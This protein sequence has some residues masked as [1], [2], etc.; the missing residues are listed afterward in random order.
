M[1][2]S[3]LDIILNFLKTGTGGKEAAASLK[4]V[5]K[6]QESAEGSSKSFS[7]SQLGLTA[8]LTGVTLA[9]VKQL[10]EL[11]DLGFSYRNTQI[12]LAAYTG[13]AEEAEELTRAVTE[14]AGGAITKMTAM[15]NATRLLSLGLADNADTAAELT[16]IA[17]TLG[18]TMGKDAT[19]AFE[20]FTLLL[21]NQSI[22][23]L[24]T[25][26]I[27][28]GLVRQRMEELA[29][30][31]PEVD[32]QT[33]FLNAT[34]EIARGRMDELDAAGFEATSSLDVLRAMFGD[35]KVEAATLVVNAIEPLID[36][37]LLLKGTV[38]PVTDALIEQLLRMRD[39]GASASE[40]SA[41][42]ARLADQTGRTEEEIRTLADSLRPLTDI[43]LNLRIAT[44]SLTS[45][46]G[47]LQDKIAQLTIK[48]LAGDMVDLESNV[49]S[50]RSAFGELN[51]QLVFNT[52]ASTLTAEQ[53]LILARDLDLLNER[54]FN[55]LT[56]MLEM[57]DAA[58]DSTE[59][60][61]EQSKKIAELLGFYDLIPEEVRTVV[62]TE[63]ITLGQPTGTTGG[64]PS[65]PVNQNLTTA[66]FVAGTSTTGGKQG[67][68][69]IS[70]GG[71]I[72]PG[73]NIGTVNINNEVDLA[74]FQN[75]LAGAF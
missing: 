9:A 49:L 11:F 44:H 72:L 27:S 25:F 39:A 48:S 29:D 1:R 15:E 75:A 46:Y 50:V 43:N 5:D 32:R 69:D 2:R 74:K 47:M 65:G 10:P 36:S 22:L 37:F 23:R 7:L 57:A 51:E 4:D 26:G 35:V 21:A 42:I 67:S 52:L 12:A 45:E 55:V 30:E 16:D 59:A 68:P 3:K 62:I 53:Q 13:S 56:S 70:T 58:G 54:T 38:N 41:E 40:M 66:P 14:A 19:G 28:A 24:D 64:V 17:I 73:V 61:E 20:E 31:M 34:L 33:R 6:A 8:A 63:F 60:F 18:A 71:D